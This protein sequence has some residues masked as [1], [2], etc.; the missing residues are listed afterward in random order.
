MIPDL[1]K[2]P[3]ENRLKKLG[4]TTFESRRRR[5]GLIQ[6]FKMTVN[7]FKGKLGKYINH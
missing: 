2:L 5:G 1:K 4:L 3:Y 7:E 6:V